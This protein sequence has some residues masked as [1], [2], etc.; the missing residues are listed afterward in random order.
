MKTNVVELS[1][2][3]LAAGDY[4]PRNHTNIYNCLLSSTIIFLEVCIY[5][6]MSFMAG[7]TTEPIA[8]K[9]TEL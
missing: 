2:Y 4:E 9:F 5:V 8:I 7:Q 1:D 3:G 6:S